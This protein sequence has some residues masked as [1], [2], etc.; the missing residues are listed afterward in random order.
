MRAFG[1]LT[2]IALALLAGGGEAAAQAALYPAPDGAVETIAYTQR[3]SPSLSAGY[4]QAAMQ[5]YNPAPGLSGVVAGMIASYIMEKTVG[6]HITRQNELVDPGPELGHR[7]AI[8]LARRRGAVVL[9]PAIETR[10]IRPTTLAKEA[11]GAR[12][13]VDVMTTN[14]FAAP[15][16]DSR[17]HY[18]SQYAANMTVLDAR[19]AVVVAN[20]SCTW[21]SPVLRT[22][23]GVVISGEKK[24]MLQAQFATAA[25][26]CFNQFMTAIDGAIPPGGRRDVAM[27]PVP[28][29]ALLP[30]PHAPATPVVAARNEAQPALARVPRP[31]PV[32]QASL[33]PAA[34]PRPAAPVRARPPEPV[35][36]IVREAPPP[37]P[38]VV[39]RAEPSPYAPPTFDYRLASAYPEPMSLPGFTVRP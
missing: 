24:L 27:A 32:I 13:L 14:W 5:R 1:G 34:P 7:V 9:E 2:V 25:D 12:Y 21:A 8:A 15:G 4:D 33:P 30:P 6:G 22:S 37:R 18:P 19:T 26:A 16:G 11:R 29:P 10:S 17:S 28:V 23:D 38:M 31:T 35:V 36:A 3:K 39:A 20:S